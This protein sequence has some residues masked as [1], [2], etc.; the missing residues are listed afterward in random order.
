V[1][2]AHRVSWIRWPPF[3]AAWVAVAGGHALTAL[4]TISCEWEAK[5]RLLAV[6]GGAVSL[7]LG[8]GGLGS[9]WS[10]RLAQRT[11]ACLALLALVAGGASLGLEATR[12]AAPL[13]VHP[14][15]IRAELFGFVADASRADQTPAMLRLDV[16]RVVVGGFEAM[17]SP[18]EAQAEPQ[19]LQ[20][21]VRLLWPAGTP[22]PTWAVA[23]TPI[24]ARGLVRPL[25]DARNPGG[26]PP[27]PW[28][29]REGIDASF[30]VEAGT[31]E[32]WTPPPGTAGRDRRGGAR[33]AAEVRRSLGRLFDAHAPA[34]AAAL[35][36]GML[37]GDRVGIDAETRD[38]FRNAG[39]LH[40]LSISGL[41]V[42]IVA[43]FVAVCARSL[44][45]GAV[46]GT[47]VEFAA[48]AA[49]V[50]FV[51]APPPALRSALLWVLARGARL[52]GRGAA[53][54]AGWGAAGLLLHLA[55]PRCPLDLGFL[56]SFGAVLGLE[57]GA[58]LSPATKRDGNEPWWSRLAR[59]GAMA[60]AAG[61]GASLGTMPIE[62]TA[63]GSI[64]IAGPIANLVVIPLTTFFLAEAI[65]LVIVAPIAPPGVGDILGGAL[66]ALGDL[67]RIANDHLG[68]RVTPLAIHG[69]PALGAVA[70][71]Y[72]ALLLLAARRRTGNGVR[73]RVLSVGLALLVVA[74]PLVSAYDPFHLTRPRPA[75]LVALDVGQ[76]DA[77]L[78]LGGRGDAIAIDAGP[79]GEHRDEGRAT[80]EPALRAEAVRGRVLLIA[81][82]GHRDHE[83]GILGLARRGWVARVLENGGGSADRDSWR[84]ALLRSGG[85][86]E[87]ARGAP[88]RASIAGWDVAV[89]PPRSGRDL[90]SAGGEGATPGSGSANAAENDR[91]L[92]AV[93]ELREVRGWGGSGAGAQFLFPGDLERAGEEAWLASGLDSALVLKVPHHGSR[94][95]STEAWVARVRPA[96]AIVSVGEG[97][98]YRHPSPETLRRYR[99]AG[100]A[101]L[102]TDREGAIRVTAARAGLYLATR[103]HPSPRLITGRNKSSISPYFD[104]P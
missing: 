99:K 70:A 5:F 86:D 28:L 52:T 67:L 49:Y 95:S 82:H 15:P 6:A 39:T 102:R 12:R 26:T 7:L 87:I 44:R 71:S 77:S 65:L 45:L 4:F 32:P 38:S 61:V 8:S 9:C 55:D 75:R 23:G 24:A 83:G 11:A 89:R 36:R 96:I 60:V 62:A 92:V 2:L 97:N 88:R 34:A 68:G 37:L 72:L 84:D 100:A 58:A 16:S 13:E 104:F 22:P 94:T 101:V 42:C 103:A 48:L 25:E 10:G 85:R 20:G 90:A 81:S 78:L 43:G 47:A 41:H 50:L 30:D 29:E 54:F 18:S 21:T 64:P 1:P 79:R 93:A 53:P 14:R 59:G 46:A 3:V 74:L 80:V 40:I 91:S 33:L 57:A 27:G 56:L 66:G 69:I 76:G 63:F 31:V 17:Q 98:R 51:G 19:A 73:S 35:A